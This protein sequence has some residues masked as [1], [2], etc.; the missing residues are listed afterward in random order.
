MKGSAVLTVGSLFSGI[1][2]IDLG[3]ER[4]GMEVRWQVEIEDYPTKVLEKHW[5]DVKRY[6]DIR[7]VGKHNLE[8]V[9]LICGGFPCQ[10]ISLAGKG[11]GLEGDR[12]GLWWEFH[13]I[14]SEL[15]PRYI[16][17]ENVSALLIRGGVTVLGS[18]ATLGYDAS[19]DCIPAAAVGAPHRRDRLFIVAY[20]NSRRGQDNDVRPGGNSVGSGGEEVAITPDLNGGS[21]RAQAMAYT[22]CLRGES[23]AIHGRNQLQTLQRRK[24]DSLESDGER[25]PHVADT[26]QWGLQ[27]SEHKPRRGQGWEDTAGVRT[28]AA[29]DSWWATEPDVGRVAHGVPSRVHR[30]KGLGNAVVP[31][32][33][34]YVGQ[35]IVRH[36]GQLQRGDG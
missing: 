12:S 22:E 26:M 17:A 2:G 11:A 32:V 27:E 21:G 35:L 16:L 14:I 15:R 10:D 20:P 5:P 8:P 6:R 30:L 9:D 36:A 7:D 4:A 24:T 31:Q 3:L 28:L 34:E 25:F 23:R 18:L 1:G 33:A 29:D 13:R 19:W